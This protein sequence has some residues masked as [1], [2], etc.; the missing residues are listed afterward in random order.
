MQSQGSGKLYIGRVQRGQTR[1]LHLSHPSP[2][3]YAFFL[4]SETNV[5]CFCP[6][7]HVWVLGSE[8]VVGGLI[9]WEAYP[10]TEPALATHVQDPNS[11]IR[12]MQIISLDVCVKQSDKLGQRGPLLQVYTAKSSITDTHTRTQEYSEGHIPRGWPRA[13]HGSRFP[14]RQETVST[15]TCYFNS[16]LTKWLTNFP[17]H[18]HEKI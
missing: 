1:L 16:F 15:Q 2:Y 17:K 6:R 7:N 5:I 18:L 9:I 14:W 8:S 12:C 13:N 10:V 4:P 11:E 3:R